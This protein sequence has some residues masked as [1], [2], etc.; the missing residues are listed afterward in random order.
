MILRSALNALARIH[1][2]AGMIKRLGTPDIYTPC[3]LTPSKYFYFEKGPEYTNVKTWEFIIPV[4]T[5]TGQFAQ[6]LS[7]SA[8]P[9]SGVFQIKFGTETTGNINFDAVAADIQTALRLITSLVNVIVT[10]DFTSGFTITFAGFQTA[11]ALGQV[12]NTTLK[13]GTDNVN[14]SWLQTSAAWIDGLKRGDRI[15]DGNRQFAIEEILEM[16]DLGAVL[17]GYRC[18]GN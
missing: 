3:R 9:D 6:L 1:S 18:R 5:L 16:N 2:R 10:G 8:V 12:V 15:I 17:M 14:A 13:N 4:D 7:F 11:P